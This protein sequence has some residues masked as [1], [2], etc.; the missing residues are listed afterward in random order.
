[1]RQTFS[2][3]ADALPWKLNENNAQ[4]MNI[5]D[6]SCFYDIFMVISCDFY[7]EK[8]MKNWY[9]PRNLKCAFSI[10]FFTLVFLW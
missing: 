1:M 7:D 8:A 6:D 2:H 10:D 4:P 9:Y 5:L 3:R